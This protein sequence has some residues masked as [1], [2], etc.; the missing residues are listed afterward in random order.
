MNDPEDSLPAIV[1]HVLQLF[2]SFS[3]SVRD[4]ITQFDGCTGRKAG[5]IA[6][7]Y[8]KTPAAELGFNETEG[9]FR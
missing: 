5:I 2:Q 1:N 3:G 9:A 7:N 4:L 6:A 8:T